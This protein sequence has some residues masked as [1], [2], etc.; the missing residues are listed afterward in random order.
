MLLGSCMKELMLGRLPGPVIMGVKIA[1][2]CRAAGREG[3]EQWQ[4]RNRSQMGFGLSPPLPT[5]TPWPPQLSRKPAGFL[6]LHMLFLAA[7]AL[8]QHTGLWDGDGRSGMGPPAPRIEA[9]R[10]AQGSILAMGTWGIQEDQSLVSMGP[11]LGQGCFS[12]GQRPPGLLLLG[13]R[14]LPVPGQAGP[15]LRAAGLALVKLMAPPVVAPS[16]SPH[17]AGGFWPGLSVT[18]PAGSHSKKDFFWVHSRGFC[19]PS[20]ALIQL[21]RISSAARCAAWSRFWRAP[22]LAV[23]RGTFALGLRTLRGLG[24]WKGTF[25]ALLSSCRASRVQPWVCM[26]SE[27]H[28]LSSPALAAASPCP[29]CQG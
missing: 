8:R 16:Q 15:V 12:G 27:P 20:P 14:M 18:G 23:N 11:C 3:G 22:G 4:R 2:C 29:S 7:D 26:G 9:A 1:I 28:G 17:P 6:P 25:W 19:N 10:L 13:C 24:G 21:T 5:S